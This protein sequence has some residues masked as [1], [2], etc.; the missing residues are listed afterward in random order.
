MSA[1]VRPRDLRVGDTVSA[2]IVDADGAV[3]LEAGGVVCSEAH[4][5]GILLRPGFWRDPRRPRLPQPRLAAAVRATDNPFARLDALVL[6]LRGVLAAIA[7][8][9]APA[10]GVQA[11]H[12]V[13]TTIADWA[14]RDP[15]AAVALVHS[16]REYEYSTLHPLHTALVS[17]VCAAAFNYAE[18]PLRSLIAAALTQNI[19]LGREHDRLQ[20]QAG[21]LDPEQWSRVLEHP[22]AGARQLE[23]AG[24][25]DPIWLE[26][27][28]AHHERVDGRGYPLG[29]PRDLIGPEAR[30]LA[31]ADRYCALISSRGHRDGLGIERA[32]ALL[33]KA[34][35]VEVDGAAADRWLTLIGPYPP[36]SVVALSNGLPALVLRGT[37]TPES[38]VVGCLPDPVTGHLPRPRVLDL[39]EDRARILGPA[40][41]PPGI[42]EQIA[43]LWGSRERETAPGDAS[44]G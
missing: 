30:F 20:V 11:M 15:D 25:S 21:Q 1:M 41:R 38:P 22:H 4:L 42:L 3:L 18:A 9:E 8:D 10:A 26:A 27:V 6:H 2:D 24:V 12:P 37:D 7:G 35:G 40:E 13:I 43:A 29:L 19:A 33:R 16:V 23:A 39:R 44:T 32:R 14:Q 36:G 28:R 34:C 31:V 17:A 5:E